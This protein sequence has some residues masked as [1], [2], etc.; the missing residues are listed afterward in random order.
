MV[1]GCWAAS[2]ALVLAGVGCS[3]VS[4]GAGYDDGGLEDATGFPDAITGQH[5]ITTDCPGCGVFPGSRPPTPI[6]QIQ[7]PQCGSASS[8][9]Q[10]VYPNDGALYPPNTGAIDVQWLPGTGNNYFE[11]DFENKA[12]DVRVETRCNAITNSIGGTTGGCDLL[13]DAASWRYVVG[14]NAGND[15]VAVTVR[16]SPDLSCADT[17][18]GRSMGFASFPIQG[19]VYYWQSEVNGTC[20]GTAG[21]IYRY[22]FGN[23]TTAAK[24]AVPASSGQ[25][26]G[27]HFLSHDGQK[28]T[29]NTD[30]SDADDEYG[31]E[32]SNLIDIAQFI[33]SGTIANNYLPVGFQALAPDHSVMLASDGPNTNNPPAFNQYDGTM[34]NAIATQP[35]VP[36]GKR[37]TQPDWSADGK[38]LV[39]VE[40]QGVYQSTLYQTFDDNHLYGGSLFTMTV[41]PGAAGAPPTFGPATPFLQSAGENNYYPTWSPDG[42]FIL[43]NREMAPGT[44]ST[45]GDSFSNPGAEV[46]ITSATSP[47]P[48]KLTRLNYAGIDMSQPLPG[49]MSC[50]TQNGIVVN[51]S[52]PTC[53]ATAGGPTNSWPRFSP[54]VQTYKGKKIFWV[55]FSSNRDYGLRV[56]NQ[57]AGKHNCYPPWTPESPTGT[58][59]SGQV[60]PTCAQ[61]QVWMAAVVDDPTLGTSDTSF[62]AFWL[63]FQEPKAHNHSAQW[64]TKAVGVI[65]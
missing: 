28:M 13:L 32:N 16:G 6:G 26:I 61:P 3:G 29:Y 39:F 12:T 58:G 1:I 46:W 47:N 49:G 8:P 41:S 54:F 64:T 14:L 40:P 44:A 56:Q 9:P 20:A 24:A 55:T 36:T 33:A 22:D 43:F 65:P 4:P 19:A 23:T 63:P 57:V 59:W 17:S 10:L 21:G 37:A 5:I 52:T 27:C 7:A 11:V 18:N 53:T 30:D 60:D 48:I 2:L 34:G 15:P 42:Q 38:N 35:Q 50:V 25:C 31:D 51:P 62:P 45:A